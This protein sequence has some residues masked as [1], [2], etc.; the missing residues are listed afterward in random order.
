[1]LPFCNVDIDECSSSPCNNSGTCKD[2]VNGFS[3]SCM[4]GFT[5]DLCQT[6]TRVELVILH[7]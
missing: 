3:C 6:G 2:L 4:A 5:G 1:M 7:F